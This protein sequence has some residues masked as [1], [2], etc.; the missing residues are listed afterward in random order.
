MFRTTTDT[1]RTDEIST[2]GI[3]GVSNQRSSSHHT[4]WPRTRGGMSTTPAIM[5]DTAYNQYP[6]SPTIATEAMTGHTGQS[7]DDPSFLEPSLKTSGVYP[8]GRAMDLTWTQAS[9]HDETNPS[10]IPTGRIRAVSSLAISGKGQSQYQD[11]VYGAVESAVALSLASTSGL[12]QEGHEG[13]AVQWK[14]VE[15]QSRRYLTNFLKKRGIKAGDAEDGKVRESLRSG[16]AGNGRFVACGKV[17]LC[18]VCNGNETV[19]GCGDILVR[20]E[21]HGS[22]RSKELSCRKCDARASTKASGPAGSREAE[23]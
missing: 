14:D 21:H 22:I 16:L 4:R 10:T 12:W 7:L 15:A 1:T 2:H 23:L 9:G 3:T 5:Y 18:G 8:P 11:T 13:D 20:M 19:P 17:F 6:P